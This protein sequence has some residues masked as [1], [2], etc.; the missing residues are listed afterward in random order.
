MGVTAMV[1]PYTIY[2][3][4]Y[5]YIGIWP[6]DPFKR[7]ECT[8]SSC[9]EAASCIIGARDNAG[10]CIAECPPF[11]Y[12]NSGT[13]A[14]TNCPDYCVTCDS[15]GIICEECDTGYALGE[16]SKLCYD[17]S[18][19]GNGIANPGEQC[20]ESTEGCSSTCEE[21]E[22]Y[23]CSSPPCKPKCGDGK[24]LSGEECDDGNTVGG[25]GCSALCVVEVA[26]HYFCTTGDFNTPSLCS[27][28]PHVN[29]SASAYSSDLMTLTLALTREPEPLNPAL[30]PAGV[31]LG[32]FDSTMVDTFGDAPA[33]QL[34]PSSIIINL[35][36]HNT[37]PPVTNTLRF[38]STTTIT[39]KTGDSCSQ[40]PDNDQLIELP[41]I[42]TKTVSAHT[43]IPESISNCGVLEIEIGEIKGLYGRPQVS[44]TVSS[45]A[46]YTT[47]LYSPF[48]LVNINNIL[49][50][51]L[52]Y[53]ASGYNR[54]HLPE[55]SLLHNS[56]YTFVVEVSNFQGDKYTKTENI[57]TVMEVV[58][59]VLIQGGPLITSYL[60]HSTLLQATTFL[61]DCNTQPNFTHNVSDFNY[62]WLSL[63]S[64][65]LTLGNYTTDRII[66][67]PSWTLS[68]GTYDFRVTLQ[69][70]KGIKAQA[71]IRLSLINDP[72]IAYVKG[73]NNIAHSLSLPFTL[74]GSLSLD[75]IYI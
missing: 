71:A 54:T 8:G 73:G 23:E 5:I 9:V 60:S 1:H 70:P 53:L 25:D 58:G 4:I 28:A 55:N 16:S 17:S 13:T 21:Q 30:T 52:E 37:F 22:G 18:L 11:F 34:T 39:V 48:H 69:H 29:T 50:S 40:N 33:C 19:C 66:A 64:V 67:I 20:D 57:S 59:E 6:H 27:C 63:Q 62:T 47:Q 45:T 41:A 2:I 68:L 61:N 32:L 38:K 26:S 44:I 65:D 3:Y 14:C 75:R 51:N 36:E 56:T 7:E 10:D 72:L 12:Y 31:C 46:V 43:I 24:H 42:P 49:D 35:G 15:A 74:N